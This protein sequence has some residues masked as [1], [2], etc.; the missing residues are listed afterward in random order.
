MALTNSHFVQK[1]QEIDRQPIREANIYMFWYFVL[2]IVFGV[3]LTFNMIVSVLL[4]H[5]KNLLATMAS[6]REEKSACSDSCATAAI[7][8]NVDNEIASSSASKTV[9]FVRSP[10]FDKITYLICLAFIVSL[11][12]DHYQQSERASTILQYVNLLFGLLLIAETILRVMGAGA[13]A[14]FKNGW[15]VFDFVTSI[16]FVV[17]K[18]RRL[19]ACTLKYAFR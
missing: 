12:F 13:N 8:G 18:Q 19:R 7:N 1:L 6:K 14:F 9:K 5:F 16:L 4:Q 10:S 3:F 17:G 11:M 2:F 15:N